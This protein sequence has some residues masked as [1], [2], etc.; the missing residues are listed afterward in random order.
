MRD[1]PMPVAANGEC[2]VEMTSELCWGEPSTYYRHM[3][4][5]PVEQGAVVAVVVVD[6]ALIASS[7]K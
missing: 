7:P 4:N 2:F 1:F 5:I 6:C 3:H